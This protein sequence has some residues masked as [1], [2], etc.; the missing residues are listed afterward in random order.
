MKINKFDISEPGLPDS[1]P[2]SQ[3]PKIVRQ[4]FVLLIEKTNRAAFYYNVFITGSDFTG[5]KKN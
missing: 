2:Q 1:L 4:K 5:L 3:Q